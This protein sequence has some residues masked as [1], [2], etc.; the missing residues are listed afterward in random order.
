MPKF[1]KITQGENSSRGRN[2]LV[3]STKM[4]NSECRFLLP[5]RSGL[6]STTFQLPYK[7]IHITARVSPEV[8]TR[9]QMDY[10]T[11]AGGGER[12]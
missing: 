5:E 8:K 1:E 9:N 11:V 2:E 7:N 4:E 3:T 6:G 10:I 12:A